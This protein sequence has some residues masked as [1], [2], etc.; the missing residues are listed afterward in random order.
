[1]NDPIAGTYQVDAVLGCNINCHR[2]DDGQWLTFAAFATSFVP[3]D[4][5]D[6]S[7]RYSNQGVPRQTPD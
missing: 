1:M 5:I 3:G 7:I 4:L 6:V 2:I